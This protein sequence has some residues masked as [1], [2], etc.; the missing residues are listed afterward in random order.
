MTAIQNEVL[1]IATGLRDDRCGH[2]ST[3]ES[4][5]PANSL[6]FVGHLSQWQPPSPGDYP[7]ELASLFAPGVGWL[8][9]DT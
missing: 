3:C 9:L 7:L 6:A 5:R 8:A 2:F 1:M 4:T